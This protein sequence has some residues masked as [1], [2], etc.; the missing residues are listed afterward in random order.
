ML[1]CFYAFL[2]KKQWQKTLFR[3]KCGQKTLLY[4]L[5]KSNIKKH[6]YTFLEKK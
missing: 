6:F 3:K 5:G 1:L 2:E 4:F